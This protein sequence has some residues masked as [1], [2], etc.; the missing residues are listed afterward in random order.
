MICGLAIVVAS[1][2][3]HPGR[4]VHRPH[5]PRFADL[6]INLANIGRAIPSYA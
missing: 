2:I 1:L 5:E 3:A 6:A 4:A